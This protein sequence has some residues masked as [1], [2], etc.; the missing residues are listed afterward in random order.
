M[1]TN[2]HEEELQQIFNQLPKAY[3][4]SSTQEDMRVINYPLLKAIV[5]QMMDKAYYYGQV[6]AVEDVEEI[7]QTTFMK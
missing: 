6:S 5:N 7:I 2:P 3:K 1:S 4:G